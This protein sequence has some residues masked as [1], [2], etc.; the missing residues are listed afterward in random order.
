M[1]AV[2]A[3][4]FST[5]AE[6]TQCGVHSMIVP[7]LYLNLWK[8][9]L[10]WGWVV[11]FA[12]SWASPDM[13]HRCIVNGLVHLVGWWS[14]EGGGRNMWLFN[15]VWVLYRTI[16]LIEKLCLCFEFILTLISIGWESIIF[17]PQLLVIFSCLVKITKNIFL[18]YL[19]NPILRTY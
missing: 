5:L 8:Y 3:A 18:S 16:S 4:V 11:H 14:K 6:G 10:V 1:W 17:Y 19:L 7:I 13:R 15:F 9:L 12:D 2:A